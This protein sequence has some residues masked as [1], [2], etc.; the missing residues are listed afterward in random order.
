M[1]IVSFISDEG[2]NSFKFMCDKGHTFT[3][4]HIYHVD[5]P[6]CNQKMYIHALKFNNN[7]IETI[8]R[9]LNNDS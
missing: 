3:S 6:K 7:N 9:G 8:Y 4:N 5:C 2:N 1:K